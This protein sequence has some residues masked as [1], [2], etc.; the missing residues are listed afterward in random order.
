MSIK[1]KSTRNGNDCSVSIGS[2][3]LHAKCILEFL[4]I[5]RGFATTSYSYLSIVARSSKRYCVQKRLPSCRIAHSYR[6]C[7]S[8]CHKIC[9]AGRD[10]R[11][12]RSSLCIICPCPS[13]ETKSTV[14]VRPASCVD[15]KTPSSSWTDWIIAREKDKERR[16]EKENKEYYSERIE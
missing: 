15:S 2:V 13:P 16:G 4:I 11:H 9:P 8:S 1:V 3:G 10:S 12:R 5:S 7:R 14:T 6:P